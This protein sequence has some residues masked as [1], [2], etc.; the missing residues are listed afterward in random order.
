MS[1][2]ISDKENNAGVNKDQ[3]TDIVNVE[4]LYSDDEPIGKILASGIDKSSISKDGIIVELNDTGKAL[5]ET[6]KTCIEKKT[7]LESLIKSLTEEGT[8]GNVA[9]DVEE[10]ENEE[11][12][13]VDSNATTDEETNVSSDI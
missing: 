13:N 7:I 4:D 6:I 8:D 1:V 5:D 11:G 9:G 12:E 3:S 10:E 2:D